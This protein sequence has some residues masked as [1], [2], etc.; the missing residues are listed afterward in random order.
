MKSD[1]GSS[2]R[3][4]EMTQGWFLFSRRSKCNIRR[5]VDVSASAPFPQTQLHAGAR[6]DPS[7]QRGSDLLWL[8]E[9]LRDLKTCELAVLWLQSC[10][11]TNTTQK[12]SRSFASFACGR[13]GSTLKC[14]CSV[15]LHRTH[16]HTHD[17]PGKDFNHMKIIFSLGY[18]CMS[19]CFCKCVCVWV[20]V[21]VCVCCHV[22]SS[23]F[24]PFIC[25]LLTSA[26]SYSSHPWTHTLSLHPASLFLG[27]GRKATQAQEELRKRRRNAWNQTQNLF[28]TRPFFNS[29]RRRQAISSEWLENW[30]TAGLVWKDS[31]AA[32]LRQ[33]H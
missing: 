2:W 3:G 16:T 20:C 28:R 22:S 24:H 5:S 13:S 6:M 31:A 30:L 17:S 18:G 32:G 14:V 26:P 1:A 19:A 15:R 29:S 7:T 10:G 9:R 12:G 25:F 11:Q 8:C 23:T 4:Y 33:A 21:C 27:C